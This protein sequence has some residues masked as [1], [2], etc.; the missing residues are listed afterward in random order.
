MFDNDKTQAMFIF[1]L[2][3]TLLI[4]SGIR[5]VGDGLDWDSPRLFASAVIAKNIHGRALCTEP[6]FYGD[7]VQSSQRRL[8][9]HPRRAKQ[10]YR[11]HDYNVARGYRRPRDKLDEDRPYHSSAMNNDEDEDEDE[12]EE[13]EEQVEEN[14]NEDS[15]DDEETAE[16]DEEETVNQEPKEVYDYG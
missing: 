13:E 7:F 16:Q 4:L 6:V 12:E 9:E 10:V 2:L 14:Q 15:L 8:L 5:T 3:S 11:S 1:V